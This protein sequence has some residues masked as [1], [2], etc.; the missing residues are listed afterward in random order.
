MANN[1]Y[2]GH[3]ALA[4]LA[5]GTSCAAA[6]LLNRL[7]QEV[8]SGTRARPARNSRLVAAR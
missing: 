3:I 2:I 8:G 1:S 5:A 4:G 7:S 6:R